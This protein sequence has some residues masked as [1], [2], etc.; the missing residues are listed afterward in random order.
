MSFGGFDGVFT[1]FEFYNPNYIG[2]WY[3]D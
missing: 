3:A 1:S 2:R